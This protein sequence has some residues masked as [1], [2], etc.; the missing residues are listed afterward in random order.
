ML[1]LNIMNISFSVLIMF[2]NIGFKLTLDA[3]CSSDWIFY[4]ESVL[5]HSVC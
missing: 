1:L 5:R 4:I 2:Y 3:K